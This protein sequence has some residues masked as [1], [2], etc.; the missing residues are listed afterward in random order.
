MALARYKYILLGIIIG[1]IGGYLYYY[2]A[3]CTN[4][5]CQIMSNPLTSTLYGGFFG[6]WLFSFFNKNNSKNK[7]NIVQLIKDKKGTIVDVRTPQEFRSAHAA[8][9]INIPLQE[10]PTKVDEIKSMKGPIILCCASGNR[11]GQAGNFLSKQ[12]IECYNAGS[13]VEVNYTISQE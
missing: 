1:A 2:F 3:D 8:G 13:W 6:G 7:M 9:S 5:S 11:S 10:L 12:G 4:G